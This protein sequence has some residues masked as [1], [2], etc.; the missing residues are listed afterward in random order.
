MKRQSNDTVS[1]MAGRAGREECRAERTGCEADQGSNLASNQERKAA[2][3]NPSREERD[4]SVRGG[5][6]IEQ[7]ERKRDRAE[8][9][10]WSE[11]KQSSTTRAAPQ[12]P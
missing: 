11:K 5:D 1:S 6:R 3:S 2:Q 7:R 8:R 10:R 12:R 4:R 9:T